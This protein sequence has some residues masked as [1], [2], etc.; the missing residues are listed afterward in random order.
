MLEQQQT[1]LVNGLQ[2]M[3]RRITNNEG[4]KGEHLDTAPNGY[5]L[6][7]D[8]LERLD[9]LRIDGHFIPD[10]FEEDTELLRKR[11]FDGA[12][13][14]KRQSSS[15]SDSEEEEVPLKRHA[16]SSKRSLTDPF[17]PTAGHFPPTPP[18]QTPPAFITASP[19]TYAATDSILDSSQ[20][21]MPHQLWSYPSTTYE[22][23]LDVFDTSPPSLYYSNRHMQQQPNPC[24]PMPSWGED[25]FGNLAFNN[26]D[27][28][29]K[30]KT[31]PSLR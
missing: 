31:H 5:P 11:L 30:A 22:P 18:T 9:A 16:P 23:A 17:L 28:R 4:W 21:Q 1:Q 3:Y 12:L 6:T 14:I 2:E 26:F 27:I 8:I 24:L 29:L 13:H 20:L 25:E 15:D 7:H 19:T 10:R